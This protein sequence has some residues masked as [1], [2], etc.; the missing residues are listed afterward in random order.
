VAADPILPSA[1]RPLDCK[2]VDRLGQM[3]DPGETHSD[4]ILRLAKASP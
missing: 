1:R 4:V 2:F 3:R